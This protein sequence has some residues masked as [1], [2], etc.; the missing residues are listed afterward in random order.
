MSNSLCVYCKQALSEHTFEEL[1]KCHL[2]TQLEF[3]E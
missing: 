2:C 1:Q 3:K